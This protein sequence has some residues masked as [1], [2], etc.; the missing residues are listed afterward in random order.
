M[1][2]QCL[3]PPPEGQTVK[4]WCLYQDDRW[5]GPVPHDWDLR[6]WRVYPDRATAFA[7]LAREMRERC[8]R[9][10]SGKLAGESLACNWYPV[11]VTY[12]PNGWI[13]DETGAE[14]EPGKPW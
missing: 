7:G 10:D 6:G 8:D 4:G 3:N 11:E 13:T 9:F 5:D 2:I 12:L 1:S 14:F